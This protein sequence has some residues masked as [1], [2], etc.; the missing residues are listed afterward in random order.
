M[1]EY[2]EEA[3]QARHVKCMLTIAMKSLENPDFLKDFATIG[4][5]IIKHELTP[6]QAVI[7]QAAIV[8]AKAKAIAEGNENPDGTDIFKILNPHA[9][10]KDLDFI[11][12]TQR[13]FEI[14]DLKK[15]F[16]R[17]GEE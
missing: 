9:P 12:K 10:K 6:H 13:E 4:E 16:E 11:Q 5:L 8:A 7:L 14:E 2:D 3:E 17:Q 15:A 1:N